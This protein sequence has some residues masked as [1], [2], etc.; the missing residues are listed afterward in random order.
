MSFFDNLKFYIPATIN[1]LK[2][3]EQI[4]RAIQCYCR[5]VTLANMMRENVQNNQPI[6][7][8][9]IERFNAIMKTDVL[10][11]QKGLADNKDNMP[12]A[13]EMLKQFNNNPAD[14]VKNHLIIK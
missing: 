4:M 1:D 2:A 6:P 3:L 14:W 9:M 12:T 10:N 13:E 5:E 7:T 11:Q 8:G